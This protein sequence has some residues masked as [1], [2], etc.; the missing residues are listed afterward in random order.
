LGAVFNLLS[1]RE[2]L[3]VESLSKGCSYVEIGENLGVSKQAAHKAVK[4]GLAKLREGLARLGYRGM[5]S[6]GNLGSEERQ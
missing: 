5:A 6:D 4:S 3:V 2:R 1:P